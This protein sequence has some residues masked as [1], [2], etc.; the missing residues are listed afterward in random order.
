MKYRVK[1]TTFGDGRVEYTVECKPDSF[2]AGWEPAWARGGLL[3][4][5]KAKTRNE[6]LLMI[7]EFQQ[8]DKD[9]AVKGTRYIAPGP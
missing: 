2:L 5:T 3:R 1:E 9:N 6:C 4:S 7:A 8:Q